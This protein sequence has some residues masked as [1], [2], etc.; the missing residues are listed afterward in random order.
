MSKMN[1]YKEARNDLW[2]SRAKGNKCLAQEFQ[3]RSF[4]LGIRNFWRTINM[5]QRETG[6]SELLGEIILPV[7]DS[8]IHGRSSPLHFFMSVTRLANWERERSINWGKKDKDIPLFF[9]SPT[10]GLSPTIGLDMVRITP[11]LLMRFTF[12]HYTRLYILGKRR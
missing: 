11:Q 12:D 2:I 9:P 10:T 7:C 5:P 6:S 1:W 4:W 8:I 3:V